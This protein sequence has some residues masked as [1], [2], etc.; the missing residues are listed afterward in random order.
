MNLVLRMFSITLTAFLILRKLTT[1][2]HFRSSTAL[3]TSFRIS[4][5]SEI[6][7]FLMY[8]L[9]YLKWKLTVPLKF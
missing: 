8:R 4:L 9:K 2:K 6:E 1:L 5:D 7:R 3:I